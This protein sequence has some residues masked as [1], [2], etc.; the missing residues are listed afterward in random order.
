MV[1]LSE[2]NIADTLK[3][4]TKLKS[5]LNTLTECFFLLVIFCLSYR[6][7]VGLTTFYIDP[8]YTF[9]N[10]LYKLTLLAAGFKAVMN[11]KNKTLWLSIPVAA[12]FYL[13]FPREHY[14][15]EPFYAPLIIGCVGVKVRKIFWAAGVPAIVVIVNMMI[16]SLGG[17]I[18]SMAGIGENM[19]SYWGHISPTDFGTAVFC[20]VLFVW[21]MFKDMPDVI[22]LIITFFSVY[23]SF[24]ISRC[25]TSQYLTVM[26]LVILVG[27]I[28]YKL[29]PEK[30][31]I[32]KWMKKLIDAA[33]VMA[34]T[35]L[36]L[37]TLI[38]VL[39]YYKNLPYTREL[40]L[41]L[42]YRLSPAAEMLSEYGI[43]PFG[44]YF[45]MAGWGGSTMSNIQKYTFIDSSY[46]QILIRYGWVT[47]LVANIMWSYTTW[48]AIKTDNRKVAYAMTLLAFD[49]VMEHH[50]YELSY[51][52]FIIIPFAYFIYNQN[53]SCSFI[54][55]IKDRFKD[56]RYAAA[57]TAALA[58][59][60]VAIYTLLPV[61]FS[62]L[63]TIV[64]GYG[65]YGG[66]RRG[67]LLF[68]TL[69]IIVLVFIAWIYAFG[70]LMADL[71]TTKFGA[72]VTSKKEPQ[73]SLDQSASNI[74]AFSTPVT[75]TSQK[76][77]R[78]ADKSKK[79]KI[80]I[81][82]VSSIFLLIGV[83]TG[84]YLIDK[85]E[86]KNADR[87]DS[88]REILELIS[89]NAGGD[90]YV[91]KLP[92]AY[93]RR[94]DGI[95]RSFYN[96]EDYARY[97]EATVVTDASW[98]SQ[99]LIGRGF[100]YLQVSDEDAIYTNDQ[101]V[102]N[103][104]KEA[105][106]KM[107]GY[108]SYEYTIDLETLAEMNDVKILEDGALELE[109]TEHQLTRCPYVSLNNGTYTAKYE[110]RLPE[111][112][113]KDTKVCSLKITAF[114][115]ENT[116]LDVN[117]YGRDFDEK[118]Q[119]TYEIPFNGYGN[120]CEFLVNTEERVRC[121]VSYIGYRRTPGS[122]TH[123]YIDEKGRTVREE[124]YDTDGNP[125]ETSEDVY[126]VEY[127]YDNKDRIEVI[128]YLDS[129]MKSVLNSSGFAEVHRVFDLKDQVIE[130]RY[131]G[132]QGEAVECSEGYHL[133]RRDCDNVGN[134]TQESFY[135][136]SDKPVMVG[137]SYA[138]YI[139]TF[140]NKNRC[141]R[142]E[143][144]GTDGKLVL[145]SGGYAI[146]EWKHD[147]KDNPISES[148]RGINNEPVLYYDLYHEIR[149]EFNESHLCIHEEY[150][151]T[152]GKRM[153]IYSAFFG[154]DREYD[155][156]NNIIKQV[157]LGEDMEP[158]ELP[159]GYAIWRRRYN[160]K[161]QVIREEYYDA[162]DTKKTRP[163]GEFAV[164]QKY[165]DEG[166]CIEYSYYGVDG[167]RILV[168]G[169]YW[170]TLRTY[171]EGLLIKEEFFGT[172]DK[173]LLISDTYASVL[174]TY[175]KDKKHIKSTYLD[176]SGKVVEEKLIE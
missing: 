175:D 46:P 41:F 167:E 54:R 51:N 76:P 5:L 26:F 166:N 10:R 142:I 23:I 87:I 162:E 168:S 43:K 169:G 75:T 24:V 63:R 157:Y 170:K 91:D 100:L 3:D 18:E 59:S 27:R 112:V 149:R 4:K 16:A 106:Y 160:S 102:I 20:N 109:G 77:E 49:F 52:V 93:I 19:S 127:E 136:L 82:G 85:V 9:W 103:A 32:I 176:I 119:L 6:I 67:V 115:G 121:K 13:A 22:T 111:K 71:Y 73:T 86:Q 98:D 1:K 96:G 84:N 83:C 133:V 150:Y 44:T 122:D 94:L 95:G 101:K 125:V 60:L 131:Y 58:V 40:D 70:S 12:V 124:Y 90:L 113:E 154:L 126:G 137:E 21:V 69:T 7:Q 172:D 42:H 135:D 30:K 45:V 147:E 97:S 35:T 153:E 174:Y 39:A 53:E 47:Y 155:G 105:G 146:I 56:K 143:Y 68:A 163:S 159:D 31:K 129:D 120:K 134:I 29:L 132:V 158:I 64:N 11:Y 164:E 116:I 74:D 152:E 156:S 123:R 128:R 61:G 72:K 28:F 118:G 34:F 99:C 171:D 2:I 110:L 33:M 138:K 141:I 81:L 48:K 173:P 161:N 88:E 108:N 78:I 148:Y 80:F 8:N 104:L 14:L 165:D 151:D 37:L 107:K 66:G 17:A 140:D 25:N 114:S 62:W 55:E 57:F 139:R 92:E 15:W 36:G 145:Q 130:E 65:I 89:S 144:Y 79:P 50:W 117:I 38:M